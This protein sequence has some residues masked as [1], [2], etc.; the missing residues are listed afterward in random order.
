MADNNSFLEEVLKELL[1]QAHELINTFIKGFTVFLIITG[2]LVKFA[3][4]N[5]SN[6]KLKIAL[7]I[8]GISCAVLG[9]LAGYY[10]FILVSKL[11][12]DIDSLSS[13]LQISSLHVSVMALKYLIIIAVGVVVL[14][15]LGWWF[16][17][18]S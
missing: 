4:D 15:F 12:G 2:A 13:K 6:L 3:L 5:N 8:L 16:I 10:G 14:I 7:S 18:F 17:L 11:R 1:R 9:L